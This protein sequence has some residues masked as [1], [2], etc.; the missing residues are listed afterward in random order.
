MAA[1]FASDHPV[2]V[3]GRELAGAPASVGRVVGAGRQ[4]AEQ[5][6]A[7]YA[8]RV[9][10]ALPFALGGHAIRSLEILPASPVAGD[11]RRP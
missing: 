4:P 6:L 7:R 3:G 8:A 2:V 11:A 9:E 1:L 5:A 10:R